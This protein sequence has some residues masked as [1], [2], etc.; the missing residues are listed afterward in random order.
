MSHGCFAGAA[1][2]VAGAA[3]P[4]PP[5]LTGQR[6]QLHRGALVGRRLKEAGVEPAPPGLPNAVEAVTREVPPGRCVV[7]RGHRR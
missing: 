4:A 5:L 2:S 7:P 6:R 3:A 1:A